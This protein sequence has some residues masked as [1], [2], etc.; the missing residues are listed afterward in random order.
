MH[1]KGRLKRGLERLWISVE[2]DL[3]FFHFVD[4]LIKEF[5]YELVFLAL[6]NDSN[7]KVH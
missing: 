6:L 7:V 5:C 2:S 3:K 4:I 1:C